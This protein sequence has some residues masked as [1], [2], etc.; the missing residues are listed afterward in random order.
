ML[1][2]LEKL[3][4]G[5]NYDELNSK[6]K[7]LAKILLK[8]KIISEHKKILYLNN[9]FVWG[10]IDLTKNGDAYLLSTQTKK[11]LFIKAKDLNSALNNDLVF[12]K[13]KNH[14]NASVVL[15]LKRQS[16][17]SIVLTQ[18]L[19]GLIF[20]KCF[21]TGLLRQLK[22]SQKSLK[23]LPVGTVLRINNENNEIL[24]VLGHIS[25]DLVDEKISM[26][27]FNKF[28]EF[29]KASLD[30]AKAYIFDIL[31]SYY[32][33]RKDF[34]SLAFCTIDPIH[35]KDYDDAIYFDEKENA[36]Y[37]A[38]ADV[39]EYVSAFSALDNEALRRGFSIYFPHKSIPMLPRILSEGAC[40]LNPNENKLVLGFKIIF[41][42]E[43]NVQ[44][45]ELF[46]AIINSK[47]RF[48]YDEVDEYL[49]NPIDLKECNYIYKLNKVTNKIRAKRLK[50]GFNFDTK[51][52]RLELNKEQEIINTYYE[53]STPSHSLIEECMLLANKAAAKRLQEVGIFR[54][55]ES[56]NYQK[57][58]KMYEELQIIGIDFSPTNSL[59]ENIIK[60]QQLADEIG[61][62]SE[63]DK[64]I[65]RSF[66]KAC[67][68]HKNLGHFALGFELYTHFTSP[69]R[70]YSD[71]IVHRLLKSENEKMYNYLCEDIANKANSI[72]DLERSAQKV[73][74][75]FIDRKFARF[76]N[77]RIGY[78]F[79]A[80][81][82]NDEDKMSIAVLDD[83]IKGARVFLYNNCFPIFSN[84]IVQIIEVDLMSASIFAKVIKN[85]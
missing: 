82:V 62:R 59:H 18:K 78:M 64:I 16:E 69:I 12:V 27:L 15:V 45:E 60:I 14:S 37:V 42:S 29:D 57:I 85:V 76:A 66:K 75:D 1:N 51:E 72:S 44:S 36:L 22:A 17:F 56:P 49:K 10:K 68:Q 84:V 6:Q 9:L 13:Q 52:L 38:I 41:D 77:K 2:F 73:A 25:D 30:E 81:I 43:L 54:N 53:N 80:I 39:S 24:E 21:N 83:E 40:S 48:N 11:D 55:H 23:L 63:V 26:A 79:K 46:S 4:L 32:P 19:K 50:N 35:A 33:N 71:L 67:Y 58:A 34:S 47:R 20:G 7:E 65:I 3:E 70:R 31:P 74:L 8:E 5:V 61:L 28:E